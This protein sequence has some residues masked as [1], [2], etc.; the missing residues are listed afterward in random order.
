MP[1]SPDQVLDG[2]LQAF[3]AKDGK[4]IMDRPVLFTEPR[5]LVE[6]R[7]RTYFVPRRG[8]RRGCLGRSSLLVS[9]T[10][11]KCPTVMGEVEGGVAYSNLRGSRPANSHLI[12]LIREHLNP[13]V[14]PKTGIVKAAGQLAHPES[15]EPQAITRHRI[16]D[17]EFEIDAP[18]GFIAMQ[19]DENS[20]GPV[21]GLSSIRLV[22]EAA[23][24]ERIVNYIV[25]LIESDLRC[26]P[27]LAVT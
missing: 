13:T 11:T 4:P 8:A 18:Y 3:V 7:V 24:D 23:Y 25:R 22:Q 17:A 1:L 5:G 12:G 10:T 20:F 21:P 9:R 26:L 19:V 2:V 15:G 16:H 27:A 14:G 6:T